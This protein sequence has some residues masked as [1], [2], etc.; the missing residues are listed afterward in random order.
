MLKM[1]SLTFLPAITRKR[2]QAPWR[3]RR[4]ELLSLSALSC[5]ALESNVLGRQ[6]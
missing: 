3:G 1:P 6:G 4:I 5:S 2:A